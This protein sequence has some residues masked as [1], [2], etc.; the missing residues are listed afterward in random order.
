MDIQ[1]RGSLDLSSVHADC[2][3]YDV[4]HLA[5]GDGVE[6][7]IEPERRWAPGIFAI[8]TAGIAFIELRP[9]IHLRFEQALLMGLRRVIAPKKTRRRSRQ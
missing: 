3:D 8:S 2:Y 1:S 4:K 9:R 5:P 7:F 6:V